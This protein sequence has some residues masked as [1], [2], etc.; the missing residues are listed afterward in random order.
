VPADEEFD[1]DD[2]HATHV[3]A[4]IGGEPVGTGRIVFH[5]GYAKIGRMA[6]LKEHRR[7]GIGRALMDTLVTAAVERAC[8][9]LVLHAQVHAT[10]FYEALG[11]HVVG[12]EFGEA[13]IP[14]RRMERCLP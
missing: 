10:P 9:Q 5:P 3:L 8:T 1:A 14:H 13:G 6:V 4:E 12:G 7:R 2:D 11:F